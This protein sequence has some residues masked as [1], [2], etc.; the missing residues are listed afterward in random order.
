MICDVDEA[1]KN[2]AAGRRGSWSLLALGAVFVV[3]CFMDEVFWFAQLVGGSW[4]LALLV[5]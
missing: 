3:K 5:D 4:S 2:V 1:F